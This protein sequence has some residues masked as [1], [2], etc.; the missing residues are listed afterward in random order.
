MKKIALFI[1]LAILLAVAANAQLLLPSSAFDNTVC[2][3]GIREGR[4][5][6]DPEGDRKTE[7]MCEDLGK[8]LG[9]VLVCDFRDCMCLPKRMDCG[10][11]IREGSEWC[12]PGEKQDPDKNDKCPELSDYLGEEVICDP[13]SC[14]CKPTGIFN[15]TGICGDARIEYGEECESDED[16]GDQKECVNCKCEVIIPDIGESNLTEELS[17]SDIP[18]PETKKVVKKEFNYMDYVGEKVPEIFYSDF[19]NAR[20]NVFVYKGEEPK[21]IIGI[22]TLHRVIQEIVDEKLEDPDYNLLVEEEVA[23]SIID[24]N[25][26]ISAMKDALKTKEIRYKPTGFFSKIWFWFKGIF[27]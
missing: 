11:G 10:N 9:I 3:D 5:L 1:A 21:K 4:E 20:I 16:C 7:S 18:A 17:Q 8:I 23:E 22:M 19:D 25:D 6:C 12:D 15:K 14:L 24:A 13:D 26:R 2:G 27:R